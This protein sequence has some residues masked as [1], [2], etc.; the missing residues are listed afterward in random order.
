MDSEWPPFCPVANVSAKGP[1]STLF[2][3]CGRCLCS[4]GNIAVWPPARLLFVAVVFVFIFS[5]TK[6][7]G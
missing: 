6:K 1:C 3:F 7:P 2:L 5:H 4:A